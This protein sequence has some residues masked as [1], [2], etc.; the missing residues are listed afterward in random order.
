MTR[1]ACPMFPQELDWLPRPPEIERDPELAL[2]AVLHTALEATVLA[3]TAA[4]PHL[5]TTDPPPDR[6]TLAAWRLIV[7]L[8][9][10]QGQLHLYCSRLAA[11]ASTAV[12]DHEEVDF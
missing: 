4:H 8:W 9:E 1:D 10:F 12:R 5:A 7:S 3:L 2:L 6:Q 11:A